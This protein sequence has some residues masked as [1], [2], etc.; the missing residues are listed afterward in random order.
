VTITD[1]DF[2]VATIA[3]PTVFTEVEE[4]DNAGEADGED[5]DKDDDKDED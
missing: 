1:R 4:D 3:A 2:T 5:D